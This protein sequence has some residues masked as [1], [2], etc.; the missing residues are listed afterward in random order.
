MIASPASITMLQGS[1]T[2]LD[3][4]YLPEAAPKGINHPSL[5]SD[6]VSI[7]SYT[8]DSVT[9]RAE[10]PGTSVI[11]ISSSNNSSVT[12]RATVR[13]LSQEEATQPSRIELDKNTI[14]VDTGESETVNA[15]VYLV[16]G[17]TYDGYALEWIA[18]EGSSSI[19]ITPNGETAQ[20]ATI[21]GSKAGYA[22]VRVSIPDNEDISATLAIGVY[23]PGSSS[24]G[25]G[26]PDL[27][28]IVPNT[29]SL[30]LV[31]GDSAIIR[32]SFLPS[33]TEQRNF[34]VSSSE[35]GIIDLTEN[36][37]E[38]SF[39]IYAS[40]KGSA[41]VTVTSEDDPDISADISVRVITEEESITPSAIKLT[42]SSLNLEIGSRDTVYASLYN[43]ASQEVDDA[44]FIWEIIQGEDLIRI[45][46]SGERCSIEAIKLG[47]PAVVRVT[48]QG[49][50]EITADLTNM[51]I[52]GS[53]L[54]EKLNKYTRELHDITKKA[55]DISKYMDMYKEEKAKGKTD[56]ELKPLSLKIGKIMR[57]TQ[58]YYIRQKEIVQDNLDNI[59]PAFILAD[60][61]MY[62]YTIP[63]L[64]NLFKPEYAYTKHPMAE[65][66]KTYLFEQEEKQ[67]LIGIQFKDIEIMG[68]D[69]KKHKL[70]EYCGKG[71]YVLI[72]FWAS[73]CG[74]CLGD[75]PSL[76][77][78]YEKYHPKGF[79]IVAISLDADEKAWKNCIEE[80]KMTWTNLSDL[81]GWKSVAATTYEIRAIPSSLLV[82]PQGK[83][84]AL[85]LRGNQLGNKLKEI[86]GF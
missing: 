36:E 19:S 79:D 72:D 40:Q 54:N 81:Q 84:V 6:S 39:E 18:T 43:A 85:D 48:A 65:K 83:I 80:N 37:Y 21:T 30:T 55:E 64:K 63:E 38:E 82:D 41:T 44:D 74:P 24:G 46:P 47:T 78:N 33:S 67:S 70:S 50:P 73:W 51:K 5:S 49:Y 76:K 8:E 68:A 31:E 45:T 86:Y 60:D 66:I 13:V 26:S 23:N 69:G 56:E 16:T 9:I 11:T 57:G 71:R 2:T 34:T 32:L 10:K 12:T 77:T 3:I 20:S 4:S 7:V 22:T 58:K 1:Q 62:L 59:I 28:R 35:A 42:T 14:E 75:M 17:E 29:S 53:E 25:S 52:K 27:R 61:A 15:T